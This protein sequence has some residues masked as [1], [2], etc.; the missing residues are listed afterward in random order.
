MDSWLISRL[1]FIIRVS[2]P[3]IWLVLPI[4]YGLGLHA[5]QAEIDAAAIG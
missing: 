3:I 4:V 2:R 5:A 1:L